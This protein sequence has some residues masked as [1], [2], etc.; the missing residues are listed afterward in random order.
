M[1]D[2]T[3][4][5]P[6]NE[7]QALLCGL[8]EKIKVLEATIGSPKPSD[9]IVDQVTKDEFDTLNEK[10]LQ[11]EILNL[12]HSSNISQITENLRTNYQLKDGV[13]DHDIID[14]DVIDHDIIDH[15]VIDPDPSSG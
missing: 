13:I 12:Q 5:S 2:F 6:H 3:V 7:A 4:C 15:D 1:A 8:V 9:P 10:I 11:L 14:H